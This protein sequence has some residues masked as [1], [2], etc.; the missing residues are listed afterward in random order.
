MSIQPTK[1]STFVCHHW[2]IFDRILFLTVQTMSQ[3]HQKTQLLGL[4]HVL[5]VVL[6]LIFEYII[7]IQQ[8]IYK[9]ICM[10]YLMV[11]YREKLIL[12]LFII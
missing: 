9:T 11:V 1:M 5:V 3:K 8:D 10:F 7:K 4:F 2:K 12:V 6:N